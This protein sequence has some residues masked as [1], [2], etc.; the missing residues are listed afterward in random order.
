MAVT[1]DKLHKL[2]DNELT[3]DEAEALRRELSDEELAKLAVLSALSQSVHDAVETEA[4]A[5]SI[6]VWSQ[7]E[8]KLDDRPTSNVVPLRRKVLRRTTAVLSALALAATLL[9]LLRPSSSRDNSCDVEELEVVGGGATVL[10]VAD[11]HGN[12][13]TLIWF[14]HQ[15]EDEWESL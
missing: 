13:T 5:H 2:F 8:G 9:F 12:D 3:S 11:E 6:D 14:D 7:I 10:K 15:E 4:A 1:D